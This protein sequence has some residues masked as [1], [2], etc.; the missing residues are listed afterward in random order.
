MGNEVVFKLNPSYNF[1]YELFMPT[2]KKRQIIILSF[3]L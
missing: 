3:C 1:I 2:G